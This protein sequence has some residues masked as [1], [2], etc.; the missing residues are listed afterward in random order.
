MAD[1]KEYNEKLCKSLWSQMS[2]VQKDEVR[3]EIRKGF[4]LPSILHPDAE[5]NHAEVSQGDQVIF[6]RERTGRST[7]QV[8]KPYTLKGAE[9]LAKQDPRQRMDYTGKNASKDLLGR[10]LKG[11]EKKQAESTQLA[12]PESSRQA[13]SGVLGRQMSQRSIESFERKTRNQ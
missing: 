13:Q 5:P 1:T 7:V 8:K 12:Q 3:D 6:S 11:K 10:E 4:T 9:E 2:D